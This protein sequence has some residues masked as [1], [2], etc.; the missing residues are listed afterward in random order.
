MDLAAA[1]DARCGGTASATCT[2]RAGPNLLAAPCRRRPARRALPDHLA[3]AA[4]VRVGPDGAGRAREHVRWSLALVRHRVGDHLFTRY[5]RP[6]GD[7]MAEHP[8]PEP[9]PCR[10][11]VRLG[12]IGLGVIDRGVTGR[13]GN[14]ARGVHLGPPS[15]HRWRP[16]ARRPPP[17]RR[18]CRRAPPVGPG[19]PGSRP[20]RSAGNR[21]VTSNR[22]TRRPADGSPSIARRCWS[23]GR[24]AASA[25]RRSIGESAG[26]R[27]C[28]RRSDVVVLS[29]EPGE[30][31][32]DRVA[33]VAAG[34]SP[35]VRDEVRR[36][37]RRPAGTGQSAP[38]DCLS[39]YRYR[40]HRPVSAPTRRTG[41]PRPPLA[42][43]SRSLDLRVRRPRRPGTVP[44]QQ[45]D[46]RRRSGRGA[47]GARQADPH[48]DRAG[49]RRDARGGVRRPV[50]GP[51]G[52]C[53]AGRTHRSAGRMDDRAT[54]VAVAAEKA[55]DDFAAALPGVRRRLP[56]GHDPRARS[57]RA[58]STLDARPGA[59]P[60]TGITNGGSVLLTL[61][62]T[63]G[64]PDGW[65]ELAT[66]LAAAADGNPRPSDV[67]SNRPSGLRD[68]ERA[69]STPRS[70]TAATTAPC[71]SPRRS[72]Q[73]QWRRSGRRHRC[74][75]RSQSDSSVMCSSWPA[76]ETALG[77]VKA[78]GAAPI[79]VAGCRAGPAR[80]YAQVRSLSGPTRVGDADQLA[81]RPARQLPASACVSA[82]VDAYLL[83]QELPGVGRLCPP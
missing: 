11:G 25:T 3:D 58:I 10:A 1:I 29:G 56:T 68:G 30:N 78:A 63:L 66:A 6:R 39:G 83:K 44:D 18:P 5:R 69:G 37:H 8:R 22:S 52:S 26:R 71:G 13:S 42:E 16:S 62:L 43:L 15:G 70:S 28:R 38:I 20:T 32:R 31:G 34:L 19:G 81:V 41:V 9:R 51:G 49:L 47:L 33:A 46:R 36:D 67:C 12:V 54:E 48:A 53:R 2:V 61:L 45:H 23:T 35:A 50:P 4:R 14:T 75:A 57:Q 59:G 76:P 80:T 55:L 65:P 40:R 79:L 64:D 72:C 27:R 77:A 82:A 60:G 7:V 73:R 21:A 74:S 24:G 17:A